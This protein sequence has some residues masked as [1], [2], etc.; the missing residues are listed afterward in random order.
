MNDMHPLLSLSPRSHT[1]IS[2]FPSSIVAVRLRP[3][4]DETDNSKDKRKNKNMDRRAWN[5]EKDGAMSS[6]IQKGHAMKVEGRTMFHFD[7]VFDEDTQ[8]PLLYKSIARPMVKTVLNG[9]HATI[10][11]YG[12]TGSGTKKENICVFSD[13]CS[14]YDK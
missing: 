6:L 5:I 7:H 10:F 3:L 1:E 8:T 2:S 4:L 12:Q 13:R 11:A 14:L 9:K